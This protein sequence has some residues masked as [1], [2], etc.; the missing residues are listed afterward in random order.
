MIKRLVEKLHG[1]VKTETDTDFDDGLYEFCPRCEANLRLQKGYDNSL[2]FWKCLGCGEMLINPQDEVPSGIVWICDECADMLNNQPGFHEGCGK[3]KCLKCGFVNEIS[4]REIYASDDEYQE[5]LRNPYRGLKD[6]DLL[7]LMVYEDLECMEGRNDVILVRNVETGAEFVKKL[8]RVFDIDIYRYLMDHP[9]RNMPRIYGIY[10]S[11]ECLIVIEEFIR[12]ET[13]EELLDK[14]PLSEEQAIVIAEKICAVLDALHHQKK[15]I[16]HRDIKPSNIIVDEMGGVWLLDVNV[17]KWHDPEQ[18]DDTRYMG[19]RPFAAPEQAGFGMKA[20]SPK[21]DIYAMGILLNVMVTGKT[22]KEEKA[23]GALWEVIEK[24]I[25][26]D[27]EE[28]YDASELQDALRR[29]RKDKHDSET[30]E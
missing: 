15:P 20:S 26:L 17:A 6:D 27:A 4:T 3:W 19:T 22:P 29:I 12:G 2:P 14:A 5:E 10:E 9:V 1:M 8:L 23:T 25:R 16:V 24:C 7:D 21:T 30:N 18:T 28:R 13:I 11:R